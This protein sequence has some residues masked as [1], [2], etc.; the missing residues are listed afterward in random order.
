MKLS[1][2]TSGLLDPKRLDS[3]VPEKRRAIR[4][5]VEAGMKSGG[6]EIADQV[7]THMGARFKVRRQGFL[8]SL[9]SKVYAGSPA[10][11]PALMIGS[12]I[13]WLGIHTRGGSISGKMLIPLLPEHQRIGPKAF[14]R[15]ITGLLRSG[16]AYFIQKNGKVILMAENLKENTSELRRFKRA[17]RGRTGAKSIK[18]GTELPIAVLVPVVRLGKRLDLEGI[19]KANLS[20][21]VAHIDQHLKTHGF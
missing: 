3:W 11:F 17:E 20:R 21:L 18:R 7:R 9:R 4:K 6:R 2:T 13:S 14:R 15:V 8:R 1:I 12:R 16:N 5:A 19:V 10:K